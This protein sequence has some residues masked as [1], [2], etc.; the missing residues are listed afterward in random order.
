MYQLAGET[1]LGKQSFGVRA[2]EIQFCFFMKVNM[3]VIF[4]DVFKF[5]AF[6]AARSP[7]MLLPFRLP[8]E[9]A[10]ST[11]MFKS[12]PVSGQISSQL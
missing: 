7:G 5:R 2:P 4:K 10:N 1:S 9:S 12:F 11:Y 8:H 3:P 6:C